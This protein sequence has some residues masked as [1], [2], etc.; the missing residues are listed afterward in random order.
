MFQMGAFGNPQDPAASMLMW[1]ELERLHYPN[2]SDIREALEMQ[3]QQEQALQEQQM[4][5]QQQA[6][7]AQI[8]QQAQKAAMDQARYMQSRQDAQRDREQGRRDSEEQIR[9]EVD[10]KARE[11]AL[12]TAQA[13]AARQQTPTM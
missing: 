10:A 4:Q 12:R 1:Q 3:Q 7:Q 8:Q 5:M 6:Q 13:M 2:A 9:R 11:D